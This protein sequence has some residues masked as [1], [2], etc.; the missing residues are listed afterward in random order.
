[1]KFLQ[2][3][4]LAALLLCYCLGPGLV[5]GAFAVVGAQVPVELEWEI[6]PGA[7][8][9][10]LEF[11]NLEGKR[12]AA[13]KSPN[14]IFKFK[15]KIGRYKVRSRVADARKVYG[16]WSV[17]TEFTV[18]PPPPGMT[19]QKSSV[20][21]KGVVDPK[22][23][24]GEVTFHWAEAVGA[25]RFR[26]KVINQDDKVILDEIVKGFSYTTHL[27]AGIYTTVLSSISE[28]GIE[29]EPVT[30]PGR[31]VIEAVPLEKPVIAFEEVPDAGNPKVKVQRLPMAK[32]GAPVL[33]WKQAPGVA[34]TVGT[35]E[36]RYF[37]GEEWIPVDKFTSKNA[38]EII[39]E[40]ALKPGRYRI[41]A[42]AELNGAKKSEATTY[43]FVVKPKEYP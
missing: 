5:T 17:L 22:T 1:M 4:K 24:K 10:E 20:V 35:L 23:M 12:L 39:L 7:K 42:W 43:E 8:L 26:V 16:D 3:N 18:Q 15:F 6:V 31:V 37:F 29:S 27:E 40:K 11:Q 41:A 25:N 21:T 38:Q 33:R 19:S 28:E 14:H 32:N 36:Y 2:K 30:L 9:Y 13:F 34:D